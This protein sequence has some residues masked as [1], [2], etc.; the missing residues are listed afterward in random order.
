MIVSPGL[1]LLNAVLMPRKGLLIVPAFA[2]LPVAATKYVCDVLI[3]LPVESGILLFLLQAAI[4]AK[5]KVNENI[6][7]I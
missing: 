3:L 4:I 7:C 2:S 1:A 5:S 6:C